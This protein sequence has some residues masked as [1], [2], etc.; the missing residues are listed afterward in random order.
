MA[1]LP[2]ILTFLLTVSISVALVGQE[3]SLSEEQ[4]A[5]IQLPMDPEDP[6]FEYDSSGGLRKAVPQD[7]VPTPKLQIFADGKI[8]AGG[9]NLAIK[10]CSRVLSKAELNQFL[11]FVVNMCG[12]YDLNTKELKNNMADTGKELFVVDAP[13]SRF[14]INLQ[15]GS[16]SVAIYGLSFAARTFNELDDIQNLLEI[17]TKCQKLIAFCHLGS[18][19]QAA[20]LL[21]KI[22][23][24]LQTL[25]PELSGIEAKDVRYATRFTDGRFQ[26]AFQKSYPAT[27]K[28]QTISIDVRVRQTGPDQP[29][30]IKISD[31][32]NN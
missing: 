10:T 27:E 17:Q 18:E 28:G 13:T 7:F 23:K 26:G 25:H 5:S 6:V 3:T 9:H 19:Q 24:Q 12:F 29:Y 15:R 2:C 32:H 30:E 14:S 1:S 8:V 20:E 21:E 22:N 31:S 16:N 11:H 4:L